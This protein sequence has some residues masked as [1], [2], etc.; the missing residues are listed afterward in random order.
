MVRVRWSDQHS[1]WMQDGCKVYMDSYTT[2]DGSCFMVTWTI[3]KSQIL[4]V[5]LTQNHRETNALWML[6]TIG[7]LYFIMVWGPAW[8]KKPRWNSI[9]LRG[10]VT[11]DFTN[12]R[13]SVTTPHDFGGVLRWPLGSHNFMVTALGSCVKQCP[14]SFWADV[15]GQD[16]SDS[17]SSRLNVDIFRFCFHSYE[18]YSID[19]S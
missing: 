1:M 5:G 4:E 17:K 10:P 12:T 6:T 8:I 7:S 19:S 14:G 18:V 9:W 3:A 15:V 11:Y 13:G 2:L 16:P